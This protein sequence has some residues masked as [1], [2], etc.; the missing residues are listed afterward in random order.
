MNKPLVLPSRFRSA[1]FTL[2]EVLVAA[3]LTLLVVGVLL[4]GVNEG[5]RVW[6]S[7]LDGRDQGSRT[8]AMMQTMVEDIRRASL[9]ANFQ[10]RRL[11]Y[12]TNTA[13]PAMNSWP[14]F[15]LNTNAPPMNLNPGAIFMFSPQ[16]GGDAQGLNGVTGYFVR[17]PATGLGAPA[18]GRFFT[19][20][21]PSTA[22]LPSFVNHPASTILPSAWTLTQAN[23]DAVAPVF[24]TNA[25]SQGVFLANGRGALVDS[26]IAMWVRALDP[27][28]NPIV[29]AANGTAT[30]Y[31][32]DSRRGYRYTRAGTNITVSPPALPPAVEIC[33]L[34][35]TGASAQRSPDIFFNG[36]ALNAAFTNYAAANPTN[37]DQEITDYIA[38]LPEAV[39]RDVR[40]YRTIVRIP[41]AR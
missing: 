8:R 23:I 14:Q 40:Q 15:F 28:G 33:V 7:S 19:S 5:S 20:A 25:N 12:T 13:N 2:I 41:N 27:I 17:W 29:T 26:V 39:Q 11:D 9:D 37:F 22:G 10:Q 30:G 4:T 32:F 38:G 3:A 21:F 36:G 16:R 24:S 35:V 34:T 1:A 6:L 31:A 18:I